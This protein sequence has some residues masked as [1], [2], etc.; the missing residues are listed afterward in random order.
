MDELRLK[1]FLRSLVASLA[2]L[3]LFVCRRHCEL[4][5]GFFSL[6]F[7]N[8]IFLISF[9]FLLSTN[10]GSSILQTKISSSFI[11]IVRGGED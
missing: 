5:R 2:F 6:F 10:N 8:E 4:M 3:R 7:L 9:F 11:Y 1:S